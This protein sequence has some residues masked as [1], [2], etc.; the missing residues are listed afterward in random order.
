MRGKRGKRGTSGGGKGERKEEEK[1]GKRGMS[2]GGKGGKGTSGGGKGNVRKR[3]RG[4]K[5][6]VRSRKR[7]TSGGG[8]GEY[9]DRGKRGE[10]G[11]CKEVAKGRG[12]K[13][14]RSF[15]NAGVL[16]GAELRGRGAGGA[17]LLQERGGGGDGFSDQQG[18]PRRPSPPT[19]RPLQKLRGGAQLRPEGRT[20]LPR[21]RG[22]RLHSRCP[23]G[24]P[25]PYPAPPKNHRGVRGETAPTRTPPAYPSGGNSG[26]APSL[27]SSPICSFPPRCC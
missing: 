23:R 21:S 17:F 24:G 15:P 5:G 10:K 20:F 27:I 14:R 11:E 16:C 2:E 22:L 19:P 8:K 7:G 12:R 1:E 3:K 18:I 6:N 13:R 4:K 25:S 26:T 9:Q